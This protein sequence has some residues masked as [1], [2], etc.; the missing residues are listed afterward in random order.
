MG[1]S[2]MKPHVRPAAPGCGARAIKT[3]KSSFCQD[4]GMKK[5]ENVKKD[6]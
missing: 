6:S 1:T 5:G 3:N 4:R 2:H